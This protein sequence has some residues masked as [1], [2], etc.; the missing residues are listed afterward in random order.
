MLYLAELYLPR[1][2]PLADVAR[3]ARAGADRATEGGP[4][5]RF[6]QAVFVP[7]DES[8]FV[9]YQADSAADVTAAGTRAGLAFDRVAAAVATW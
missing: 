6:V 4:L 3:R 2:V 5:V 7:A 1:G 9:L 8:C